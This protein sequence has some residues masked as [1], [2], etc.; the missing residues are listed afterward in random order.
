MDGND[1]RAKVREWAEQV[2]QGYSGE[3]DEQSIDEA[4]VMSWRMQ[5]R[6]M[7]AG[8]IDDGVDL[9]A[10][11]ALYGEV[12]RET[13]RARFAPAGTHSPIDLVFAQHGPSRPG[14]G[15]VPPAPINVADYFLAFDAGREQLVY[16]YSHDYHQ[17]GHA[18][19]F[20]GKSWAPLSQR[21]Y[22]LGSCQQVWMGGYDP[23]RNGV[24]GWSFDGDAPI[25]V[26]IAPG[27]LTVLAPASAFNDY[28]DDPFERVE[29]GGELPEAKDDSGWDDLRGVFGVDRGRRVTA[30]L[31]EL[32]VW[33][34]GADDQWRRC[35]SVPAGLLPAEASGDRSFFGGGAGAVYDARNERVVF[36]IHDGD[37]GQYWFYSW[38]GATLAR[39]PDDGFP[40]K[41]YERF[42]NQGTVIGEHPEQGVVA[43]A[44]ARR[45]YA[46]GESGWS[47]IKAGAAPPA[48]S[49]A[50]SMGADPIRGLL[51]IGPG[52][53]RPSK[54]DGGGEQHAFY[55][56]ADGQW[57][58][59]GK[60]SG[61][62]MLS[63][64]KGSGGWSVMATAGGE[65]FA[66][67]WRSTLHTAKW[68]EEQGWEELVSEADGDAIFSAHASGRRIALFAGPGDRLHALAGDGSLFALDGATWSHV[69]AGPD[70]F[71]ERRDVQV[72]WDRAGD[73]VVVFGGEVNERRS[74]DT[75]VFAG[76]RWSRAGAGAPRPADYTFNYDEHGFTVELEL[77]YDSAL[78]QVVRYGFSEVAVLEGE[79]WRVVP[80]DR[81]QALSSPRDRMTVHDPVTGETLVVSFDNK[82]IIRVDAGGCD[83]VGRLAPPADLG[84]VE[85]HNSF[86]FR[87]RAFDPGSRRL[88]VHND[89]DRWGTFALD[90]APAFELAASL[91][92]RTIELPE[93]PRPALCL[94]RASGDAGFDVWCAE[95]RGSRLVVT[96]GPVGEQP[97]VSEHPLGQ[98]A[99]LEERARAEGFGGAS[100]LPLDRIEALVTVP[101]WSLEISESKKPGVSRLGGRPSGIDADDWPVSDDGEPLGFLLQ[102]ALPAELGGGGVAVFCVTDGTA[103]EEPDFNVAVRLSP[104]QLAGPETELPD[105]VPELEAR[106][107]AIGAAEIELDDK[108]LGSLSDRDPELAAIIES[109]A[110]RCA[111]ASDSQK[112]GGLPSWVQGPDDEL[113]VFVGQIDFDMISLGGEWEDAGLFGCMYIFIDPEDGETLVSWQYT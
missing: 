88:L 8:I 105:G 35:A 33:E 72:A 16:A 60:V 83:V 45:M 85:S 12:L 95:Q 112:L 27:G 34:L 75:F 79:A 7:L 91:G 74:N 10:C 38:D 37:S 57:S 67:G 69:A 29:V 52:N 109:L 76:G 66:V 51:M 99:A 28:S 9:D 111:S 26:V 101:R 30:C 24:I 15:T 87:D 36:W 71:G 90:L 78:G 19:G 89:G 86:P 113:D 64:I 13:I 107:I 68:S 46:L 62:S 31:T 100:S 43:Y 97:A 5:V 39:L 49:K 41:A 55:V 17:F 25:G 21:A 108:R 44:G 42:G 102:L 106:A 14:A 84:D 4:V 40:E 18:W 48:A 53:F 32:G 22:R 50:T 103:T 6:H 65:V 59:L 73:R 94:Y 110:A 1:I 11:E 80:I 54:Y 61:K 2:G 96:A 23:G 20:D 47:R 77:G 81:Y 104:E 63:E 70:G 93:P 92:P 82:L 3:L 58:R 98:A 56:C